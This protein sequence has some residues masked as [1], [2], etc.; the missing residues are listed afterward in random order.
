M[1]K[2]NFKSY[3][4]NFKNFQVKKI[5]KMN[6]VVK[7]LLQVAKGKH[8]QLYYFTDEKMYEE[9]EDY[10][11]FCVTLSSTVFSKTTLEQYDII[12]EE[13]KKMFSAEDGSFSLDT[14]VFEKTMDEFKFYYEYLKN[15]IFCGRIEHEMIELKLKTQAD[16]IK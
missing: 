11:K 10:D 16:A 7:L 9:V 14:P 15:A 12:E 8:D 4:K 6:N 5:E 13:L 1:I 3:S 2:K